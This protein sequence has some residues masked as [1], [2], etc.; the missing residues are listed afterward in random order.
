M[1][2][3]D[4]IDKIRC[5]ENYS[6]DKYY[7]V[8]KINDKAAFFLNNNQLYFVVRAVSLEEKIDKTT[9]LT[10]YTHIN[11]NASQDAGSIENGYYDML[12]YNGL[13]D[14]PSFQSFYDLCAMFATSEYSISFSD[15]FDALVKLFSA[16]KE[17]N[18]KNLIGFFGELF[19]I[20]EVSEKCNLVIAEN[21]HNSIGTND[22]YDFSFKNF[23]IEVKTTSDETME[24]EIKHS[25]IFND[26]LNYLALFNIQSDNSGYTMSDLFDYF[27]EHNQFSSNIKFWVKLH[28]EKLKINQNDFASRKFSI[29]KLMFYCNR[30]LN[31]IGQI[32]ECISKIHYLYNFANKKGCSL[33]EIF[34]NIS[35]I[36]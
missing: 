5:S 15:F 23:N 33:E 20:K 24:F 6:I 36:N 34:S 32:P 21:W 17:Q 13:I 8:Q 7:L 16:P 19:L 1:F 2:I 14:D 31:T 27:K 28:T 35:T 18:Y 12:I 3:K 25:Q 9:Y 26:K 30:D 22:K 10:L 4:E 29:K 11:I